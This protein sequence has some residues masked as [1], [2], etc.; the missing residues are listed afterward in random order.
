MIEGLDLAQDARQE[1]ISFYVAERAFGLEI[2]QVREIRGW[3]PTTRLPHTPVY[4]K[5]VINLRGTILPII[6]LAARLGLPPITPTA[7][8]VVMVVQQGSRVLGL[9]VD[10][11]SDI[12]CVPQAEIQ[13][14]PDLAQTEVRHFVT[15]LF[16]LG[17]QMVSLSSLAHILPG[18]EAQAA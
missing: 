3:T 16:P 4:V 14:P 6:D 13:A 1:L 8:H 5:G 2:G 15:G 17:D 12:I 9:L 10:A 11:V 18:S 7:R